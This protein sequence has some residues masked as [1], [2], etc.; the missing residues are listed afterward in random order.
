MRLTRA[1]LLPVMVCVAAALVLAGCGGAPPGDTGGAEAT[2]LPALPASPTPAPTPAAQGVATEEP[3]REPTEEAAEA[4]PLPT[5]APSLGPV[6]LD[7]RQLP[8]APASPRAGMVVDPLG[9]SAVFYTSEVIFHT[10]QPGADL[11]SFLDRYNGQVIDDG[12]LPDPASLVGRT[13]A[14]SLPDFEYVLIRIDPATANLTAASANMRALGLSG[15]YAF[16]SQQALALS[17]IIA[18]ARVEGYPA[19]PNLGAALAVRA[20]LGGTDEGPDGHGG[21][22]DAFGLAYAEM[23]GLTRAWQLVDVWREET[24]PVRIA[25]IDSGFAPGIPDYENP[26]F[27]APGEIPQWDVS[28]N[29]GN[30]SGSGDMQPWHGTQVAGIAGAYLDNG[31]GTAGTGGQVASLQWIRV[32]EEDGQMSWYHVAKAVHLAVGL[33]AEVINLSMAAPCDLWCQALGGIS[34]IS[35]VRSEI[36][37]AYANGVVVVGAAGNGGPDLSGDDLSAAPTFPCMHPAVICV[38]ALGGDGED[39]AYTVLTDRAYYSNYGGDV[40]IWAPGTLRCTILP[41]G[42][43]APACTGTS[44]A[45]P[46]VAGVIVMMKAFDP[47]LDPDSVRAI[48]Q[49]T[50]WAGQTD[51]AVD[52]QGILGAYGAVLDAAGGQLPADADEPNNSRRQAAKP[53]RVGAGWDRLWRGLHSG[54]DLDYYLLDCSDA[55]CS[56][57]LTLGSAAFGDVS[58]ALIDANG[59]SASLASLSS[60]LPNEQVYSVVLPPGVYYIRIRGAGNTLAIYYL[61]L[62]FAP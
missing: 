25:I 21:T 61:D 23:T 11:D 12:S 43:E 33:G 40:D 36:D 15:A 53:Q 50:A 57:R 58:L 1:V 59:K 20:P 16:S 39:G 13:T 5:Q 46:Y 24:A 45:A 28:E 31:F 35:A 55:G 27:P 17:A 8:D 38:G 49:A 44:A 9:R 34:G 62:S 3:D 4:A 2:R 54:G 60:S 56:V 18:E 6:T 42:E 30:A 32:A 7:V 37:T 10:A 52:A 48:L 29:D 22:V 51:P 14:R 41:G 47:G 19:T 26:D